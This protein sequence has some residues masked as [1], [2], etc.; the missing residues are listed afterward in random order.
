MRIII[1]FIVLFSSVYAQT[2]IQTDSTTS[3]QR[4]TVT[5]S[6]SI[7][8]KEIPLNRTACLTVKLVWE[9][10]IDYIEMKE[11]EEPILSNLKIVGSSASNKTMDSAQGIRSVK[12]ISYILQPQSLGMGYVE[13][14]GVSYKDK[15][16]GK[17]YHLKTER[18]GI[19]AV[20]AVPEKGKVQLS[21]LWITAGLTLI[22]GV[23]LVIYYFYKRRTN[24]EETE[25]EIQIIEEKYLNELKD[26]VDL[27]SGDK[28]EQFIILS[29]IFRKYLS[30][31]YGISAL[32]TTTD[33]LLNFLSSE[34]LEE[35]LLKKSEILFSK[36]DV[37][38]FSGKN[39]TQAEFDE[40]YTT[41]ETILETY[42][43]RETKVED[44]K[45]K[46][47]KK[48]YKKF[49]KKDKEQR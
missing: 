19:E 10:N 48:P 35:S 36:A 16:S 13:T 42:L 8:T 25:E 17:I 34:K 39:A 2:D 43:N 12:E 20:S 5:L 33:E 30:E 15:L 7:S 37:V 41:V 22:A 6:T 27:S 47:A 24:S 18:I 40:A 28:S 11:I 46:K 9:G 38:K 14:V 32:E 21:W 29:R 4:I 1:A 49:F 31:K 23:A 3:D 45:Q 26:K 44:E